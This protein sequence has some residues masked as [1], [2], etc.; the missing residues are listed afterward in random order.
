M[1]KLSINVSDE[2]HKRILQYALDKTGKTHAQKEKIIIFAI[3]SFLDSNESKSSSQPQPT[4]TQPEPQ[5][6]ITIQSEPEDVIEVC[7]PE[8]VTKQQASGTSIKLKTK[9]LGTDLAALAKIKKLWNAGERNRSEIGRKIGY[10][11]HTTIRQINKMLDSGELV[12]EPQE[13]AE[14]FNVGE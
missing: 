11:S 14:L 13:K 3:E 10:E 12:E 5:E 6:I 9:G 2:L 8:P 4:P 1:P 7:K